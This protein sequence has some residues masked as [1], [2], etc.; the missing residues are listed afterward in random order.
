M[1]K[2]KIR[3]KKELGNFIG[4]HTGASAYSIFAKMK[5]GAS[6]SGSSSKN[7]IGKDLRAKI[8]K[9]LWM[10]KVSKEILRMLYSIPFSFIKTII[11]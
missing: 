7:L 1:E 8:W 11:L 5:Q 9:D 6:E 10:M 4:R 2:N 3:R